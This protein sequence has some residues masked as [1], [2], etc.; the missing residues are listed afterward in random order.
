MDLEAMKAAFLAKGGKITRVAEGEGAGL[1]NADW[2]QAL[3]TP[4]RFD[5]RRLGEQI[6]DEDEQERLAEQAAERAR[7]ERSYY[8]S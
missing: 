6:A 1:T 2:R 8:K 5:A 4:G 3:R 7:E